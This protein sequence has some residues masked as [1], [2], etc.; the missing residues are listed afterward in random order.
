MNKHQPGLAGWSPSMGWT[1]IR[2][3]IS[4]T[5][6]VRKNSVVDSPTVT[7]GPAEEPKFFGGDKYTHEP[8][9][10]IMDSYFE[11]LKSF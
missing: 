2:L 9:K 11:I 1:A 7:I 8:I 6:K 3:K 4:R 5:C 10:P